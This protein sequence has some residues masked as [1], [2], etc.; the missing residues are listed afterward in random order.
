MRI[1]DNKN[2]M[3]FQQILIMLT[4]SEVHELMDSLESLNE[5]NDHVHINDDSYKHKL[6][7][8]L[9]TPENINNFHPDVVRILLEDD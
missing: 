6:T 9:Y 7:I 4:P 2:K 3:T 5:K 1:Y 8:G